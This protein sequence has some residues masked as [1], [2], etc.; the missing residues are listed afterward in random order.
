MLVDPDSVWTIDG[1]VADDLDG[2][3]WAMDFRDDM[4]LVSRA[5]KFPNFYFQ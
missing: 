2:V 1:K 5:K 4:F 3:T